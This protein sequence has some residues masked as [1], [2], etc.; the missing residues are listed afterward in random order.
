M[1]SKQVLLPSTGHLSDAASRIHYPAEKGS[2]I[3]HPDRA[4]VLCLT[5]VSIWRRPHP[6]TCMSL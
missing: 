3:W 6:S 5:R 1:K 2:W 4:A